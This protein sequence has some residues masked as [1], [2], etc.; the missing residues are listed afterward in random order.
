MFRTRTVLA[1]VGL[2]AAAVTLP[3]QSAIPAD[4]PAK[5]DRVFARFDRKDSPGCAVGLAKDGTTLYTRGYGSANLEYGA[6]LTDSTVLESGSV[7]K[8]FTSAAIVLLSQDG[9]LSLDDDIRKYLPEVPTFGG[10]KITIRHLMT[11]TSGLRDQW[12]LLGIEGRGPGR[13]VHSPMTTLDLVTH[14]KML[15]FPPGSRYLYSN[16]GYALLGIIVQRVSGKTLDAFTQERLFKPLGMTH[17]QWRDDFT[18]VVKNRATAYSGSEQAGY[19]TDMPFTNMIG[20]GG[21]L[22]TMQ[23]LLRWNENLDN[24]TVGGKAFTEALQTQMKL[25]SGRTIRYALGL[26]VASYDGV[27]EVAHG[28]STA[29]YR[30]HLARYPE[31]R[32]SI[33]VWCNYA[34]ANPAG[35]LHQ[36]ADLVL[37][38]PQRTAVQAGEPAAKLTSA[39]LGRW[40]G[41]YRDAFTDQAVTLVVADSGLVSSA[42]GRGGGR[43]GPPPFVPTGQARFRSGQ[44]D[45]AF[46]GPAGR[47]S[48]LMIRGDDTSRYEEVRPAPQAIATS[49]YTGTYASDELDVRLEVV[50]RDGKL[51]IRR[52][53]DDW[54]ELRPSYADDFQA[55][56]LGTVRFTRDGAGKVSGFSI[57]AGRVVDVRFRKVPPT[58]RVMEK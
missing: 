25:T 35:L 56:G 44:T 26:E 32:L 14:Q 29:G 47:R 7:A 43:G 39:E 51:M 15:N 54:L 57:Y 34:S 31:Q 27:R 1:V 13:Q 52:R 9:K 21:L 2:N 53:P 48:F 24:P 46:A 10:A 36:V 6:P 20:N 3:A 42:G 23:D 38:K 11:H 49:D 4:L 55:A 12:G 37:A 45:V 33:A 28:G 18:E 40:A 8:Q 16:T 41:T 50:V 5:I 30:T 58:L 19:H 17:T 22:S